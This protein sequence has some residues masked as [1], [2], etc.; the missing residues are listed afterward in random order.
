MQAECLTYPL[1]GA[2][3]NAC[4]E[5]LLKL[6][7]SSWALTTAQS[8]HIPSPGLRDARDGASSLTTPPGSLQATETGFLQSLYTA[9]AALT[10]KFPREFPT[11]THQL[12]LICLQ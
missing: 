3:Q 1:L 7:H 8:K 12:C 4:L 5:H 11:Q 2:E 10:H 9:C 6:L